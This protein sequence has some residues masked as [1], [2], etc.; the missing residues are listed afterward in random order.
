MY[1]G[2]FPGNLLRQNPTLSL[3]ISDLEQAQIMS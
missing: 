2:L 1:L 3:Q